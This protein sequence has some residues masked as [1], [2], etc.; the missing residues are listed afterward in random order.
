MA[1]MKRMSTQDQLAR[2]KYMGAKPKTGQDADLE[3]AAVLNQRDQKKELFPEQETHSEVT[4][5]G[6]MVTAQHSSKCPPCLVL[7]YLPGIEQ[8]Q[9]HPHLPSHSMALANLTSAPEFLL[10]GL[11]DGTDIH[12]LLF[13]LFL[14]VYLLN[15]LGNLSMVV[16]VRSDEALCSP[17]YYFLGHLSLVDVCF[18]T[19]T[20][21]GLLAG[22]LRP[23]RAVS[24]QECFAQMYFFVALGITESYLLAAMSYDRAVAV[25]RPL[26]YSAVMTP[27]RCAVLVGASWAVAHLHSLLHTLLISALSYPRSAPVRH[28]FC[29]MTVMLSLAISDTS[30]VE[31]AIFSEGLAVVLTPLLLVSLSY[32]RILVAVLGVRSAGGRLRA[33]STCGAHLVVVSLFFGSVLSVYFRPSSAYSASYDRLVSVVY[34][35]VTPTL[36]PFIYSLRNKEV[37][38]ALK[39]GL[40][41]R[42][43][44]QEV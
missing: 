37:K 17:M 24:F 2:K 23:G 43:A 6:V 44:P 38:G 28:F 25:C 5:L 34:A 14:G 13:L 4:A 41:W 31:T 1:E 21:P 30:A 26:H 18:T 36:N 9:Q 7:K 33:F 10:L 16:L 40:K 29:D 12:P 11:M 20:V 22:L 8:M 19:I 42:A 32:A 39:R 35:V 15:A 27:R 3:L